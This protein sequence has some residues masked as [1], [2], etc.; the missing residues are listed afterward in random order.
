MFPCC[1]LVKC[2]FGIYTI[3]LYSI[4]THIFKIVI[5]I[6][7]VAMTATAVEGATIYTPLTMIPILLDCATTKHINR[8]SSMNTFSLCT[9]TLYI[10]HLRV[11]HM[12]IHIILFTFTHISHT[13]DTPMY[14]VI[15]CANQK[16]LVEFI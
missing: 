2:T 1:W 9:C 15:Q 3:T 13:E 16:S 6:S 7:C 11:S 4:C 12:T 14:G 8:N 5:T 10:V